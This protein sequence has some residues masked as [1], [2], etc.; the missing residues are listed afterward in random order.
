MHP[1]HLALV[2]EREVGV[3]ELLVHLIVVAPEADNKVV[4][5]AL[6]CALE[7]VEKRSQE[8][9]E[10]QKRVLQLVLLEPDRDAPLLA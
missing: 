8:L 2:L 6:V 1:D 5:V 10:E 3:D 9:F 7:V 4:D